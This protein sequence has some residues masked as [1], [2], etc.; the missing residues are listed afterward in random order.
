MNFEELLAAY[1]WKA[2]SIFFKF[3]HPFLL[4]YLLCYPYSQVFMFSDVL[5][6]LFYVS[7]SLVMV[8]TV[9]I[10]MTLVSQ[11]P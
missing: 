5:S 10:L 3:A 7:L 2:V 4:L 6:R 8:P 1:S 9:L 11:L